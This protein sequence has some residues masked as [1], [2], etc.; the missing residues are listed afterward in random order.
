MFFPSTSEPLVSSPTTARI[1]A[2]LRTQ[3]RHLLGRGPYKY[4]DYLFARSTSGVV[5]QYGP[6]PST[7]PRHHELTPPST[8]GHHQILPEW[9][10]ETSDPA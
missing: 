5:L 4:N 6:L 3:R 7:A 2:R 8:L 9:R 1:I 10:D